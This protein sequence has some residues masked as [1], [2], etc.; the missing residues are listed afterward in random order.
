MKIYGIVAEY[1]PFHNGH[2]YQIKAARK[3]G[4]TH[5][6]AVM[7]GNFV[8]RGDVAI[9]DKF[10]RARLAVAG[11]VDL[12]LELPVRF[13]LSS[14][15]GFSRGALSVL[16]GLGCVE[17]IA[18][19]SECSDADLLKKAAAVSA[20]L[21]N[22]AELRE[23][24]KS[25]KSYP[26][27]IE[28]LAGKAADGRTAEVL[29]TPNN[30]L[31]VEY[32]KAINHLGTDFD[33]LP[34]LRKGAVHDGNEAEGGFASASRIRQGILSGED[35]SALLPKFTQEA[36]SKAFAEGR[37]ADMQRL[38]RVILS[39]VRSMTASDFLDLSDV[40]QGLENRLLSSAKSANSLEELLFMAKTK[41]YPMA[42]LRRIVLSALI[43]I[44]RVGGEAVA[45]YARVLALNERGCE[46]LKIAR[47]TAKIPIEMSLA[48]LLQIGGSAAEFAKTEVRAGDIYALAAEKIQPC[49][50]DY[51][52]KIQKT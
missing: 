8:Q 7:S 45:P 17:G 1:N 5:I 11:G 2:F 47:E 28:L 22:T 24:L 27:A 16:D 44:K 6:A 20:A 38:E 9:L 15:E 50:L 41:R 36:L 14:A 12:V 19:G 32:I 48:K 52:A 37:L 23:L 13:A 26:S 40:G 33:I 3:L 42:K 34:I 51:R 29:S 4:I 43:G 31:A 35:M 25:G 21:S 10:T 39:S 18:F 46:I 49:G 30:L